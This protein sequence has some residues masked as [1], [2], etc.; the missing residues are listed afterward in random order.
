LWEQVSHPCM[1]VS[2]GVAQV[3]AI[4][5]RKGQL[6][7]LLRGWERWYPVEVVT[8][9]RPRLCPTGACDLEDAPPMNMGA[10]S[11]R[12]YHSC[13]GKRITSTSRE[14]GPM[15]AQ[16]ARGGAE[17]EPPSLTKRGAVEKKEAEQ[18]G[19]L[20][21]LSQRFLDGGIDD[22]VANRCFIEF[23]SYV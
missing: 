21:P 8:I 2:W 1:R 20:H 4:R 18:A 16:T 13:V 6:L 23:I 10:D 3:M 22:A 12:A 11:L 15:S 14:T 5:R 9:E 7:A 17:G 19:N